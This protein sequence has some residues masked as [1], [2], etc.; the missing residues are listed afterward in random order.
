MGR[1]SKPEAQIREVESGDVA[2]IER[3]WLMLIAQQQALEPRLQF[4]ADAIDRWRADIR[5]WLR[6]DVKRVWV[7]QGDGGLVGFVT[8]E[9]SHAP[10]MFAARLDVF[11]S[12]IFVMESHRG[13]G[14]GTLLLSRA[15]D[16]AEQIGASGI[17]ANVLAANEAGRRFWAN[18]GG[19]P[20][21]ETTIIEINSETSF[22]REPS[23]GIGFENL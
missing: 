22:S 15:R 23:R 10:A 19:Q 7:A 13:Q 2:E 1:E 5:H 20:F 18:S 9:R 14:I 12:E 3:L 6:S 16:W 8:A 4:V 17:T 21:F 11:I